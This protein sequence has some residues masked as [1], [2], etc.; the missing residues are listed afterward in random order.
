MNADAA[1]CHAFAHCKSY[2]LD[3]HRNHCS[4]LI[5]VVLCDF[6][7]ILVFLDDLSAYQA[8]L[9]CEKSESGRIRPSEFADV[10]EI[11]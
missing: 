4:L 1:I 10:S 5:P 7:V 6:F 2:L 9:N 11:A 3:I 8:E